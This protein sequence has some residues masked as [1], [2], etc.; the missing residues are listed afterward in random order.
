M[1]RATSAILLAIRSLEITY[2]VPLAAAWWNQRST[3]FQQ[4]TWMPSLVAVLAF[5]LLVRAALMGT[6]LV[7]MRNHWISNLALLP[8]FLLMAW[9][10]LRLGAKRTVAPFLLAASLCIAA[11]AVWE[12]CQTG[13]NQIWNRAAT[14]VSLT[15]LAASLW[16]IG[17]LFLADARTRLG[18]LPEFWVLAAWALDNGTSVVFHSLFD[19][20]LG[21]LTKPWV[22]VPWLV[23]F[24]LGGFFNVMLA[25]T[26]LCPKPRSS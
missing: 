3:R 24:M 7:G 1:T 18:S 22:L 4:R 16:G 8:S 25:K 5:N 19:L 13:V 9:I 20:F 10:I 11:M 17:Q 2:L 23:V 21:H 12:A 26:F 14:L 15:L 6:A